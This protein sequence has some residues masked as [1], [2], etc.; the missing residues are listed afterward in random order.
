MR[1]QYGEGESVWQGTIFAR[2]EIADQGK[3]IASV[4]SFDGSCWA[5]ELHDDRLS[6]RVV[7]SAQVSGQLDV[8]NV[9][10]FSDLV[11]SMKLAIFGQ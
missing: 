11:V 7:C 4:I 6:K 10:G 3:L 1:I 5:I 2:P 8:R 9:Q